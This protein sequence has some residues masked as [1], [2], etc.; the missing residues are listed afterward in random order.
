MGR[1]ALL[2]V[3]CLGLSGC[4]V[5]LLPIHVHLPDKV[6]SPT[7]TTSDSPENDPSEVS[8]ESILN[9]FMSTMEDP[10]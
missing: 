8:V 7:V 3:L 1:L 2:G 4:T 9:D 6:T 10:K 5:H